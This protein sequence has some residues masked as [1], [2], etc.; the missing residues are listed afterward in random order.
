MT[1][2]GVVEWSAL[3][4]AVVAGIGSIVVPVMTGLWKIHKDS[5]KAQAAVREDLAV[6]KSQN[7]GQSDEL[8]KHADRQEKALTT[9]AAA[10]ERAQ[11]LIFERLNALGERVATVE[12]K[13]LGS[14]S[15]HF[16][17]LDMTD[18]EIKRRKDEG[19]AAGSGIHQ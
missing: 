14:I 4:G 1:T 8:A 5:N 6:L 11:D 10:D 15:R 19:D 2:W 13:I 9:H 7:E 12:T 18:S 17:G 16:S 3:I